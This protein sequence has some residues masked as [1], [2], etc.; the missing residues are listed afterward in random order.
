MEDPTKKLYKNPYFLGSVGLALI[1][2]DAA[3]P[4]FVINGEVL[5][6]LKPEE[7]NETLGNFI[8]LLKT[9]IHP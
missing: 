2:T 6:K 1:V 3:G 5:S 9:M 8:D 4:G 7:L